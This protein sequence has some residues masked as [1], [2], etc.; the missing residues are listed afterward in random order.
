M[1]CFHQ[2]FVLGAWEELRWKHVIP[3]KDKNGNLIAAKL[4]VYPGDEEEYYTFINPEA[5]HS[6]KEWMDFRLLMVKI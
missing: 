1:L 2:G 3:L 5:Y 4:L 6:L